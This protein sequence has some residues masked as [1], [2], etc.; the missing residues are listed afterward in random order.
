MII[1]EGVFIYFPEEVI[2]QTL[3]IPYN[4]FPK[5]KLV[6]DLITD[7][8]YKKYRVTLHQKLGDLGASFKFTSPQPTAVFLESNY[9]LLKTIYSW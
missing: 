5:H 1:L 8:F 4:L 7:L 2:K 6:C 9:R 3:Q